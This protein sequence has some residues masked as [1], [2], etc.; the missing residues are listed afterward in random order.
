MSCF[1]K[2]GILRALNY[3]LVSFPW[4]FEGRGDM[5]L[6]P[7]I[8]VRRCQLDHITITFHSYKFSNGCCP[9]VF[10]PACNTILCPL[11]VLGAYL[12][13]RGLSPGPLFL[14]SNVFP[15][16]S[17]GLCKLLTLVAKASGWI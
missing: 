16:T 6:L 14:N 2:V 5:W 8:E 10:I 3:V 11:A 1:G 15:S 4:N 9:G 17:V 12:H 7:Y 13:L